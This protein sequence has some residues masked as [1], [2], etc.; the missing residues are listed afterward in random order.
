MLPAAAPSAPSIQSAQSLPAP[1]AGGPRK[2]G[3]KPNVLE[4]NPFPRYDKYQ[5]WHGRKLTS[6]GGGPATRKAEK[7]SMPLPFSD[8]TTAKLSYSRVPVIAE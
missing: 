8:E 4:V 6:W 5:Q 7:M 2:K 3:K 1:P